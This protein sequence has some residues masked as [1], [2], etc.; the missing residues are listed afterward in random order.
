MERGYLRK[1]RHVVNVKVVVFMSV[2]VGMAFGRKDFENRLW[3]KIAGGCS[4]YYKARLGD[5]LGWPNSKYVGK[6]DREVE[7]LLFR[8][9][10]NFYHLTET[11]FKDRSKVLAKVKSQI[12]AKDSSFLKAAVTALNRIAIEY[13]KLNTKVNKRKLEQLKLMEDFLKKV[14]AAIELEISGPIHL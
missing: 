4:E 12:K 11:T 6:W 13:P 14:D 2:I 1:S 10:A 3:E 5:L 9:L 7:R 8:E